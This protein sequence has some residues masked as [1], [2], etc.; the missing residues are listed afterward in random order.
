MPITTTRQIPAH[1]KM[2]LISER[3]CRK[4]WSKSGPDCTGLPTGACLTRAALG[5]TGSLTSAAAAGLRAVWSLC[6]PLLLRDLL[7]MLQSCPLC[8]RYH[9]G[10]P[11]SRI[12]LLRVSKQTLA[13]ILT[14][15]CDT[16]NCS[17][18]PRPVEA[19]P[20]SRIRCHSGLGYPYLKTKY[21]L[22]R[23]TTSIV[24]G[25]AYL[26]YLPQLIL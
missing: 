22:Q 24:A 10:M 2:R 4:C 12:S 14:V 8:H 11:R 13:Y 17:D 15:G 6:P 9:G 1:T 18:Q 3:K 23:P 7:G 19:Q 20:C 25:M 26:Q 5:C 21:R 16:V